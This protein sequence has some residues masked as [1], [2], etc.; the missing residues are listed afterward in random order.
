MFG[1]GQK[2]TRADILAKASKAANRRRYKKAAVLYEGLLQETPDD[3]DVHRRI[4]P[5]LAKLKQWESAWSSFNRVADSLIDSGFEDK[6]VGIYSEAAHFMPGRPEVWIAISDLHVQ[7]QRTGDAAK[8]LLEG[9]RH[10]TRA[11]Q[12][13][14]AITLLT[15]AHNIEPL[16][17]SP[18]LDLAKLM[19]KAKQKDEAYFLLEHALKRVPIPQR[20]RLRRAQFGLRPSPASLWRWIRNSPPL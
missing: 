9:R 19:R 11:K 3:M 4:A 10:M 14:D 12:R 18:T 7:Q 17:L 8:A 6:A 2:P 1:R 5:V 16:A 13:E 15:R 20:R